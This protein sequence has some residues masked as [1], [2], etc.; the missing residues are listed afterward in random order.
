MNGNKINSYQKSLTDMIKQYT[1]Y[2]YY[3][4]VYIN[5]NAPI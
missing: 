5:E 4:L 2:S 1:Y 3:R